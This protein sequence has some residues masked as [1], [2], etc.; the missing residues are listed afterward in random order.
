[1]KFDYLREF[2][3]AAQS[4]EMQQ[5]AKDL[6]ISPSV[7][8]KHI[9]SIEQELGV[10]LFARSRK[11]ELSAYGKILLPYAKELVKLQEEYL[12]DFSSNVNKEIPKLLVGLSPIQ[13]RERSGQLIEKFMLRHPKDVQMREADNASLC[14][15]VADGYLDMAFVRTQPALNRNP[16]LVY[17]PFCT[18]D[19]VVFLP[20]EHPLAHAS[21]IS[22]EELKDE[23]ILLRSEKSA[24]YRVYTEACRK[25]GIEPAIS[26]ASTFIIYDMVRRGE[27][28]TLYLAP[29]ADTKR[30]QQQLAIVPIRPAI[31]SYIDVVFRP[32]HL[33]QL[34]LEL[35]QYAQ[36]FTTEWYRSADAETGD[37]GNDNKERKI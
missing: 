33:P 7:L 9:K 34:G 14:Q 4:V 29:P 16:E 21:D 23:H 10:H 27:G 35:L 26:F 28:V 13:F 19:M 17:I 3:A 24:I 18:D 1:M 25:L 36:N 8:S 5:C 32:R 30:S 20:P 6:R 11:T 31:T 12:Q 15:M 22:I 2:V 37:S